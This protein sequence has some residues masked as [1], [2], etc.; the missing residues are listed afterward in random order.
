MSFSYSWT[1]KPKPNPNVPKGSVDIHLAQLIVDRYSQ[2]ADA[3]RRDLDGLEMGN[4]W[5]LWLEGLH[6]GVT[7][8]DLRED[9]SELIKAIKSHGSVIWDVSR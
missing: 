1:A 5:I 6:A 3:D 8:D 7:S 9:L 2:W 4:D